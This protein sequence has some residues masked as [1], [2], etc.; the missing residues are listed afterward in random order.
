ML[1]AEHVQIK[2]TFFEKCKEALDP[3]AAEKYA[4]DPE[5]AF[6]RDCYQSN[7][8]ILSL[9]GK[10]KNKTMNLKGYNLNENLCKAI[11]KACTIMPELFEN[12]VLANNGLKD[13]SLS[14]L[15]EGLCQ[16]KAVKTFICQNN[17]MN[18]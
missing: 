8:P 6:I 17:E 2:R 13:K 5:Y 1:F 16:L 15:I 11:L 3:L 12:I 10:I 4:H 7:T 14:K 18:V 9:I